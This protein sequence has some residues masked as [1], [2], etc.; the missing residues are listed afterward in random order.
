MRRV[1]SLILVAVALAA[2]G[3]RMV[4]SDVTRF[5]SL[6]QP[7]IGAS[8]TIL[9]APGQVGSLEFQSYAERV[10]AA[11]TAQGLVPTPAGAGPADY[12]VFLRY[13]VEPGRTV[14]RGSPVHGSFG[15]GY[16]W[17]Y[18]RSAFGL[19]A[20]FPIHPGPIWPY[21]YDISSYDLYNRWLEVELLSGERYRAGQPTQ[22]WYGRAASEGTGRALPEVVPYLVTALFERFPG[23]S[24]RTVRVAVPVAGS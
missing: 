4:T 20:G 21:D 8:F 19:S 3:P 2:C 12:V 23:P 24:G 11:L 10:A 22:V 15:Y 13:G 1:L 16:D 17:P 9:P 18:R 5:H 14:I 7:A 6:P